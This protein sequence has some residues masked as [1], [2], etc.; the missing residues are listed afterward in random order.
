M[1]AA[2]CIPITDTPPIHDFFIIMIVSI[3]RESHML[4]VA[5]ILLATL[6][7][8]AGVVQA[9][10]RPTE[11]ADASRAT[12]VAEAR[13]AQTLML[14]RRTGAV[15]ASAPSAAPSPEAAPVLNALRSYPPSCLADPLP[16]T[17][18]GPLYR[19]SNVQL[20]ATD[21]AG[22]FL[23]EA[24]TITIWRVACSS[25][26][27]WNSAT[28]MRI[29]RQSQ[30]E[31]D[32]EIY[33]LFPAIDIAQGAVGFDT[34]LLSLVRVATEPNTVISDVA[35]D[36]PVVFSTTYVLENYPYDGANAFDFNLP[37]SARFDN[38]FNSGVRYSTINGIPLYDPTPA[39]YPEA[40]LDL[41]VSGYLSTNW[42][43][44]TKPG[45]GLVIQVYEA[46]GN[47]TSLVFFFTWFAFDDNGT[48]FWF[49]GQATVPRGTRVVNAPMGYLTG[50][51]FAGSGGS[52]S[53]PQVWG[54][55]TFRFSDCNTLQLGFTANAGLPAGV[56]SAS[57]T[58]EWTRVAS[59]NNLA[60][61]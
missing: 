31:G 20:A 48:P 23:R 49:F 59:V 4:R 57:G 7:P 42:Y 3:S 15:A 10:E 38:Q 25:A 60:C 32:D 6:I 12:R 40:F 46:P 53:A 37:F 44:R 55:T 21:G 5:R 30:Y 29:D 58:R 52:V 41:P 26:D 34:P 47:T 1:H 28:L 24:V 27:T 17:P 22:N 18:S 54:T 11:P 35:V 9:A 51:G 50:G 8:V 16:T 13:S 39:N 45:E 56:P 43:D 14:Q 19:N 2:V 61:E 36:S 33:P